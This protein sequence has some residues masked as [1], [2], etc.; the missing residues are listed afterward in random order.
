NAEQDSRHAADVAQYIGYTPSNILCVPLLYDDRVIGALEVLDKQGAHSFAQ[1]DIEALGLFARQAT[2]AI[3]QSLAIRH[4]SELIV[5]SLNVAQGSPD[6]HKQKLREQAKMFGRRLEQMPLYG[7]ALNLAALV[8][9][10]VEYGE[11]EMRLCETILK[12]LVEH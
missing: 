4:A 9:E 7:R 11:P 5:H 10:L 8:R 12:D 6:K 1:A 3:E 2:V